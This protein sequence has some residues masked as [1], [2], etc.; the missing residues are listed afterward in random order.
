M[1]AVCMW[2]TTRS[3][4]RAIDVCGKEIYIPRQQQSQSLAGLRRV[5]SLTAPSL[6]MN[7]SLCV[8]FTVMCRAIQVRALKWVQEPYYMPN[9]SQLKA[10]LNH[11][12]ITRSRIQSTVVIEIY[13]GSFILF[14]PCIMETVSQYTPNKTHHTR[15]GSNLGQERAEVCRQELQSRLTH[16]LQ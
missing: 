11:L 8:H 6:S 1:P 4:K 10:Q 5:W 12:L 7:A 13:Y 14:I 9:D 15:T 16:F 2:P 3:R